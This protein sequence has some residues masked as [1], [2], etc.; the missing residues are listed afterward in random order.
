MVHFLKYTFKNGFLALTNKYYRTFLRFLFLKGGKKRYQPCKVS[1]QGYKFEIPDAL[2]FV[3]QYK[4]I[5][6]DRSYEFKTS[7]IPSV[8]LDCGANVGLS[9][10]FFSIHYPQAKIIAFEAD[11]VIAGYLTANLERNGVQNVTVI[12][13][14]A[15]INENDLEFGS[16]GADGG[17]IHSSSGKK[18]KIKA[19]RL[20]D[21]IE[22]YPSIDMLKMDIEGAER[23]VLDDCKS[24]LHKVKNIFVE[25]HDYFEQPQYLS[26]ICSILESHGFRYYVSSPHLKRLPMQSSG[27]TQGMDLQLNIFAHR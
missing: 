18:V 23:E 4:E 15:W 14:A 8:I 10:L 3:W 24:V 17:S 26:N 22:S 5:F 12:T 25:Y 7:G 27:K 6:V 11:P 16:E 2:S 21:V 13:K 20:K 19:A 1:F 9:A